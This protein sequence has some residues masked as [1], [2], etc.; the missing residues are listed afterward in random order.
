L[1][2]VATGRNRPKADAYASVQHADFMIPRNRVSFS[3]LVAKDPNYIY[4]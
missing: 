2:S 1:L 3:G 4:L